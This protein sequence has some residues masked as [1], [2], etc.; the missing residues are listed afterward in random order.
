M[1]YTAIDCPRCEFRNE[2]FLS[3]DEDEYLRQ[4]ANCDGWAIIRE[5][6]VSGGK[7]DAKDG[8]FRVDGLGIPP[9]C[10]VDGCG[11]T[12]PDNDLAVHIIESHGGSLS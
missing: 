6:A 1:H 3:D 5:Q 2:V 7:S 10:P 11:K 12:L 4:C 8:E 9:Q